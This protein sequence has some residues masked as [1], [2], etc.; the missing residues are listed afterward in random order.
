VL[1]SA[2]H[3]EFQGT[4][5]RACPSRWLA[6]AHDCRMIVRA[7]HASLT[8]RT[9]LS[10]EIA[11]TLQIEF[12]LCG[13]PINHFRLLSPEGISLVADLMP[14]SKSPKSHAVTFPGS[15]PGMNPCCPAEAI[16]SLPFRT[17][18]AHIFLRSQW[19]EVNSGYSAIAKTKIPI[20]RLLLFSFWAYHCL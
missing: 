7:S 9:E 18:T 3:A 12:Y 17:R 13:K 2:L 15:C 20:A 11:D 4:G 16:H 19:L 14:L 5:C 10:S 1:R 8:S 6:Y